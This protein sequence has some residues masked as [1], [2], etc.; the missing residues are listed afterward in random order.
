MEISFALK[1]NR[2]FQSRLM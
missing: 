1:R 2:Y